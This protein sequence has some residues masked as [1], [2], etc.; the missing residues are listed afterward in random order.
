LLELSDALF[1]EL[2]DFVFASD[3]S[4]GELSLFV[5]SEES[6]FVVLETP[7]DLEA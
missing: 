5:P 4:E 7:G 3:F 6:L 1:S 2:T